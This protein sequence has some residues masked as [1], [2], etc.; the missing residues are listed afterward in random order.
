MVRPLSAISWW[1]TYRTIHN[2]HRPAA[3][4]L[5][6]PAFLSARARIS[7]AMASFAFVLFLS[8]TNAHAQAPTSG[9]RMP[10]LNPFAGNS[11]APNPNYG[12]TGGRSTL[13][14]VVDPFGL[15]PGTGAAKTSTAS[16]SQ[17]PQQ[18]ST[19]QKVTTGTKK[20]ADGTKKMASQTADFL[21]PFD[22][23]NDQPAPQNNN[24]TGS[25]SAF[26]RQANRRQAQ[27][28]ENKG[29]F[30]GLTGSQ[31]AEEEPKSVNGFLSRKRPMP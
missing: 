6:M 1:A 15:I 29:W 11:A 28:T 10:N 31:Q 3:G 24:F 18:P 5:A 22:D 23:G 14:K 8:T 7:L 17:P 20:M 4:D 25:N 9:W 27:G 16:W 19:W 21:N 26:N 13:S 30:S 12:N 2:T